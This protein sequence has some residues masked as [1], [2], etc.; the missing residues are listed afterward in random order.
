MAKKRILNRQKNKHLE[1]FKFWMMILGLYLVRRPSRQ[2]FRVAP[3][4][5][6]RCIQSESLPRGGTTANKPLR[7]IGGGENVDS[8]SR[9]QVETV[10]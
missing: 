8:E 4:N 10:Q 1:N 9:R 6:N 2:R 5:L 3:N 7:T